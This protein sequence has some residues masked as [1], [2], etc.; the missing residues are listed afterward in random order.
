MIS[1]KGEWGGARSSAMH[2]RCK[3]TKAIHEGQFSKKFGVDVV[4]P[5]RRK[6][7]LIAKA[8]TLEDLRNPPGNRLEPLAGDRKG[9]HSLRVNDQWRI[10]FRWTDKGAEDV[11]MV[12]YH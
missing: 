10:C 9:Q 6:L 12:Y 3:D 8:M 2:F 11:E 1:V 5:A 7:A 4:R